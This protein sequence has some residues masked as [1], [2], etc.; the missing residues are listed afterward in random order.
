MQISRLLTKK[1]FLGYL[2]SQQGHDYIMEQEYNKMG[3][4]NIIEFE[5]EHYID[6]LQ[7]LKKDIGQEFKTYINRW[8]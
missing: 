7:E 3:L 4:N 8:V 1:S 6:Y 2:E 5:R